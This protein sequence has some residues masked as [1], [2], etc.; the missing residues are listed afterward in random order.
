M[1][2]S[3]LVAMI[4]ALCAG[5]IAGP[6]GADRAPSTPFTPEGKSSPWKGYKRTFSA[7][8]RRTA[9]A[10]S[11]D[12][13]AL[14]DVIYCSGGITNPRVDGGYI[15]ADAIAQC[16][17]LVDKIDLAGTFTVNG[18]GQP[19]QIVSALNVLQLGMSATYACPG[20]AR[21]YRSLGAAQ[22]TKAGYENSPLVM[23]G[24]SGDHSLSC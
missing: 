2:L 18:T 20:G 10:V 12:G 9:A 22:F 7:T 19:W 4:C 23:S 8:L 6:A 14:P 16:D 3:V 15:V 21:T 17:K 5:L 1:R 24:G 11:K 13:Q